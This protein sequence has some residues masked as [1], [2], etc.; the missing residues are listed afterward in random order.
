MHVFVVTKSIRFVTEFI[1]LHVVLA[2]AQDYR[3]RMTHLAR[4]K[5]VRAE[6]PPYRISPRTKRRTTTRIGLG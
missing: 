2:N 1:L 4:S 3:V 6:D 5:L